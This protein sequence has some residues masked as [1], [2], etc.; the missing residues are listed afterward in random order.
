MMRIDGAYLYNLGARLHPIADISA[1]STVTAGEA[2]YPLFLAESMFTQL[3]QNRW[4]G[5]RT[6]ER[7]TLSSL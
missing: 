6:V 1:T 5:I 4:F 3:M 2:R 7:F